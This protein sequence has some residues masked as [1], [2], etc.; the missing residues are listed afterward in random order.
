MGGGGG[1]LLKDEALMMA[2]YGGRESQREEES[3]CRTKRDNVKADGFGIGTCL[4]GCFLFIYLLFNH[5]PTLRLLKSNRRGRGNIFGTCDLVALCTI[6]L[7]SFDPVLSP[8]PPPPPHVF[9]NYV[10][11]FQIIY[12]ITFPII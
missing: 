6:L 1:G 12:P 5:C 7:L 11:F 10:F 8:P 2:I 4:G 9:S 3:S